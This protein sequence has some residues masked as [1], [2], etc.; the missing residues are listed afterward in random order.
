MKSPL[1][2]RLAEEAIQW[3]VLLRSGMASEAD[4]QRFEAWR[5][6]DPAH[7]EVMRRLEGGLGAVALPPL[8]AVQRQAARQMLEQR[9]RR[10]S[11]LRRV[12]V[13]G[14]LGI[15]VGKLVDLHIPLSGLAS[16]FSTATAERRTFHLSDGDRLVLNARSAVDLGTRAGAHRLNLRSGSVMA[17]V[18]DA[19]ELSSI[20]GTAIIDKG[21][22]CASLGDDR[23]MTVAVLHGTASLRAA[24]GA[25][26]ILRAGEV[27]RASAHGIESLRTTARAAAAW[28]EGRVEVEHRPLSDVIAALRPYH[29]GFIELDSQAADLRVTGIFPLDPRR[30]LQILVNTLPIRVRYLTPLWVRIGA[31]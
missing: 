16:D 31:V 29:A 3:M 25:S 13:L 27:R 2:D 4:R 15:G 5:A 21:T 28:T 6:A 7:A 8:P 10:V 14:G 12:L 26:A 23:Q 11:S 19:L 24:G 17:V 9:P 22:V 30:T 20:A 18:S 1:E